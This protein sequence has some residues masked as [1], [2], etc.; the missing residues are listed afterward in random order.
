MTAVRIASIEVGTRD[1]DP[2]DV[3]DLMDSMAAVGLLHPL[4]VTPDHRLVAGGRRL[5]AAKRLGWVEVEVSEVASLADAE[6][7][8]RAEMDENTCRRDLTPVEAAGARQRRAKV[9]A[10]LAEKREKAGKAQPSSKL[11]EGPAS[12]RLTRKVAAKG[13]GYSGSTLDKVDAVVRVAEDGTQP[14][15]VRESARKALQRLDQ[16]GAPVDPIVRDVVRAAERAAAADAPADPGADDRAYYLKYDTALGRANGFLRFDAER[17]GPL[18]TPAEVES[19]RLLRASLDSFISRIE[20]ARSGLR[21]ISGGNAARKA[22]NAAAPA[23]VEQKRAG[24]QSKRYVIRV[25]NLHKI[26]D[27][28]SGYREAIDDRTEIDPAL[29]GEEAAQL[30]GDLAKSIAALRRL[31]RLVKERAK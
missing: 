30:S 24:Q 5:E 3:R 25:A 4:V 11:D 31:N 1:R 26:A 19:L 21:V 12:S 14:E 16:P 28:L 13:T 17:L 20:R 23:V 27:R 9:L 2:G 15:A 18:M 8:L 6:M 22:K 7:A 10:P 29:T